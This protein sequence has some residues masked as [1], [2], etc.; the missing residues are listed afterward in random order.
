MNN[1]SNASRSVG[2]KLRHG[3]NSAKQHFNAMGTA[4]KVIFGILF[5]VI[6]VVLFVVAFS[7]SRKKHRDSEINEPVLFGNP[8]NAYNFKQP[9]NGY[10][11]ENS[12]EGL[13]FS[14]S[15]WIFIHDWNYKFNQWK[16]I[17]NK[18]SSMGD[19][20]GGSSRAPGMWL[21][22]K[23]N[24]LHA[25]INTTEDA[26]EGCDI[27]N[28][29][30]QK[31]VNIV[32][33]LNNRTVDI[34]IDGKLER[35]CVLRGVPILNDDPI[36]VA[37]NGGFLGQIARFQYF[38]RALNPDEVYNIYSEGPYSADRYKVRFF[39]GGHLVQT[40]RM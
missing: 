33:V 37:E 27:K 3:A 9:A 19:P 16:S 40:K 36:H 15:L 23:T 24:S 10:R 20:N 17:F 6:V 18:G 29:P 22:P 14:Y 39:E 5:V 32:Y 28:I 38:R 21:Y 34:Y 35:S 25:R 1:A 11:V 31:W 13:V 2:N 30:L 8:I 12:E 7:Y 26:N 4:Q